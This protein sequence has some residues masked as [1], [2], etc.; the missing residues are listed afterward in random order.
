M[1]RMKNP[2]P[3]MVELLRRAGS[4]DPETSR[5]SY[6]TL[7][8]ALETPLQK[9]V[10]NGD[11][12]ADIYEPIYYPPGTHIEYPIDLLTPGQEKHH[13]AYTMPAFGRIPERHVGG[14][15]IAIPTY[16]VTSSIDFNA[17]YARDGNWNILNRAL[18]VLEAGFIRKK[19]IDGWR[20]IL[21]ATYNRGLSVFDS[22]VS[23]G[24]FSRRLVSLGKL[25]M[26]R[27]A[28]GNS[29]S[30][31][32][33]RMTDLYLSPEGMEDM[34]SWDLSQ[35]DDITRREIFL[36]SVGNGEYGLNRIY[37]TNLHDLDE[38]GEGQ[39]FQKYWTDVLG[40][41]IGGSKLELAIGLDLAHED[42]FVMP[43][44]VMPEIFEDPTYHRSRRVSF[45]GWAEWGFSVLDN[46][47]VL[48]LYF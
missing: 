8:K 9:G 25:L 18:Q 17:K 19:N 46:R 47:R 6:W 39:D 36:A 32:R 16:E 40:Q 14:D 30:V 42:S 15:Y 10:L 37:R 35:I 38:L 45:Y 44:R 34:R 5:A 4:V 48:A 20:T 27:R 1:P 31:N 21:M 41:A 33:G 24:L 23:A 2:S 7:A 3:E 28:G 11:I 12:L 43:W 26:R 22:H 29:T 13:I